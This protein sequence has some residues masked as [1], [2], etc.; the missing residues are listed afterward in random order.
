[1]KNLTIFQRVKAKLKEEISLSPSVKDMFDDLKIEV[2]KIK[3]DG[4]FIQVTTDRNY[5]NS[6]D[7]KRLTKEKSFEEYYSTNEGS[8]LYFKKPSN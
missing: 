1:M 6:A 4:K 8:R 2:L 5:W 3:E 7:L